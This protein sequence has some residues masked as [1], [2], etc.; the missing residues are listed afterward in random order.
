[1]EEKERV[2]ICA[3]PFSR[4]FLFSFSL[5]EEE[6]AVCTYGSMKDRMG[7][8]NGSIAMC[9]PP[10]HLWKS[11]ITDRTQSL[12]LLLL[13]T[14]ISLSMLPVLKWSC[15]SARSKCK[16]LAFY[17]ECNLDKWRLLW[18]NNDRVTSDN[19]QLQLSLSLCLFKWNKRQASAVVSK[20]IR[21]FVHSYIHTQLTLVLTVIRC[22]DKCITCDRGWPQIYVCLQV[23]LRKSFRFSLSL[24]LPL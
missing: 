3:V 11:E 16:W 12:T 19:R 9:G 18:S 20:D 24:F 7:G 23:Q 2:S 17:A 5:I 22:N 15:V 10:L 13:W 1:M 8:S 21:T 14:Y 4:V 6:E